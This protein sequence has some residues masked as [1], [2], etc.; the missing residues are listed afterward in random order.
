MGAPNYVRHEKG[1]V[2]LSREILSSWLWATK[3]EYRVVAMHCLLRANFKDDYH[4]FGAGP[5]LIKRGSFP[6]GLEQLSLETKLPVKTIRSALGF[7]EKREF[8]TC[9]SSNRGRIVT[10]INYES[11]QNGENYTDKQSGTPAASEG[12]AD[13]KP[14]AT[15]KK[16]N[17]GNNAEEVPQQEIE[18]PSL[19]S[20]EKL[21]SQWAIAWN[22][23][24]GVPVTHLRSTKPENNRSLV[25]TIRT[26][27]GDANRLTDIGL[28]IEA[29]AR[30]EGPPHKVNLD[31]LIKDSAN[32]DK[33][34]AGSYKDFGK[35][36][37]ETDRERFQRDL[38]SSPPPM[39][40]TGGTK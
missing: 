39:F 40:P 38:R 32:V 3:P 16:D 15:I 22:A 6:T 11:Y 5:L 2:M 37:P 8:L 25:G 35:K 31:W 21:F 17:N 14:A 28:A 20:A 19:S 4:D 33:I 12:Q 18:L 36:P 27:S 9:T 10:L 26:I 1:Y 34:L 29:V 30:G 24:E 23:I 13:G 7:L